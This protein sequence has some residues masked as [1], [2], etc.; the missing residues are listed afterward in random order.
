[1]TIDN[2]SDNTDENYEQLKISNNDEG[3]NEEK[4]NDY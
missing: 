1:M 3:N 4:I 2:R